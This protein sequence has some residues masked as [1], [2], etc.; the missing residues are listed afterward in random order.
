MTRSLIVIFTAIVLDAVGIG[1]IFPILPQ[2]LQDITHAENVAPTIG[3]LT[4]LYAVMQFIFAPVLGALSDRLGRRPV[5]LISLAGAAVNYL[6]LAFAPNLLLLFVGRAIAGLTSANISVATAYITDISPEETRARRF[7]LFNAM[8]GLGF[9][10]GPVLGGVLGDHWLRLP[11]IAAAALNGANLL[12]ALFI[13]PESRPGSREK[14]ALSTLNPL[15]PLRAVLEV[16]SLLPVIILFFIFS[17]TGEAYGTCWALW[18]SDAFHWSG[19]SIGLSLGAF[20][21]C[22]TLAQAFLPG[23][24]VKLF[25]ERGAILTGV[26][27]VSIALTVMAFAGQS[28]MI[29]AIMPVFTLGGIGVPAL[30]SLATRQVDEKGQGQFQG[31]LASAVSL[32]SIVAPLGFSS[33]YFLVRQQWPGAIWLSVVAVYALAV[34]L[35]L[36][37]RLKTSDPER[38]T[39][40]R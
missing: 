2:L 24:A 40:S 18:G 37:L 36:D 22:Q 27:G 32:A 11:F 30:Q 14:I 17:A 29:F 28:W 7:G 3:T 34:P 39:G 8:F 26:A 33:I 9:I 23:P 1:L 19:L 20:G 10:I 38:R 5:L 13:L 6:L 21:I 35:V 15:K 12:L 25:G 31:V 16:K 4:A